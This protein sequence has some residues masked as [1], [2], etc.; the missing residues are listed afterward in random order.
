MRACGGIKSLYECRRL[1]AFPEQ[2]IGAQLESQRAL[3]QVRIA[4]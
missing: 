4:G 2:K 1:P 3:C